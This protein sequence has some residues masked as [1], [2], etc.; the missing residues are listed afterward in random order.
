MEI[1]KSKK[2]QTV[3]VIVGIL[4][5][6]VSFYGV[7]QF[8]KNDFESELKSAAVELNKQTPMPVDEYMR[9]DSAATIGKTNF[10]YYFTLYNI[11][12]AEVH[13]DSVTKYIRPGVIAN[14]KNTP[15]LKIFRDQDVSM[16]Y[17]YYDKNGEFITEIAVTPDLYK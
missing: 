11:E 6:A 17:R 2:Q 7:Q 16:D 12:K 15:E 1:E 3:A 14:V 10:I 5:F 8:F 4:V 9:L 13:L